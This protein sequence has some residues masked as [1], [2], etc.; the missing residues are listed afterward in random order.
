MLCTGALPTYMSMHNTHAVCTKA[1]RGQ[2]IPWTGVKVAAMEVLRIEYRSSEEQPVLVT[3]EHLPSTGFC[4]LIMS[5][6]I[7]FLSHTSIRLINFN[8]YTFKF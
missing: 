4:C 2:Y 5:I 7:T 3:S 1:R 8:Y 6:A